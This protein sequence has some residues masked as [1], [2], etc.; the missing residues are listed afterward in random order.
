MPKL[1][2]VSKFLRQL[3]EKEWNSV[4]IPSHEEICIPDTDIFTDCEEV[5]SWLLGKSWEE[6]IKTD[7]F[8]ILLPFDYLTDKSF[9]YYIQ[10]Y[11]FEALK[12]L[13]HGLEGRAGLDFFCEFVSRN[14][15]I[16]MSKVL[17]PT[18]VLLTLSIVE[19]AEL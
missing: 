11:L 6:V 13:E 2:T 14:G 15:E 1:I 5:S 9:K 3:V 17:T 18:Q 12:M 8:D 10:S 16:R 7:E 19:L 4:S